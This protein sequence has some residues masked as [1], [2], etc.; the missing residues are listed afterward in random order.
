MTQAHVLP[1]VYSMAFG[2]LLG[3]ERERSHRGGARLALG[4]RTFALLAVV[5]TLAAALGTWVIVVG[6]GAVAAL[7]VVGYRRTN[8]D[9]PGTTTEVAALAT[10]LLG[11]L[12][13]HDPRLA[14][15]LA[16]SL[17]VLLA[18]KARIHSFVREIVTDTELE[19]AL[20]F[21]VI[22][23]VVLPLLPDRAVGP[24]GV[25]NP[26]RI[27]LIVVAFTGISWVGY[28]AV[29]ALGPR[30]G[31]LATGLAS[32]FVSATATTASMGRIGRQPE[33]LVPAVAGAQI[34]SV[35]T[36]IE[37]EAIMIVV[38]P[39]VALRLA[40]PLA[41]GGV[42]LSLA[43]IY[44][45]RRPK[46]AL[47]PEGETPLS[48]DSGSPIGGR[49]FA[50]M[51]ALILAVVLTAALLVGRW[52]AAVFGS[53][54]AV[55]ASG[56][57]GLADAHAGAIS[58]ATLFSKGELHI[59][60]AIAAVAAALAVNTVVKCVVAFAAGGTR[61]GWRFSVGVVPAVLV[62]LAV[63]LISTPLGR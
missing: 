9:D 38:S 52:G 3:I 48:G 44:F 17:V 59:D 27:W 50:L 55:F 53:K 23:F 51:P 58:A 57:A 63:L 13:Y 61:F 19:D 40:L 54:G 33:H 42:V 56:A 4:S 11:A 47:A 28:I 49:A 32:G 12:C 14:T 34:S 10:Y 5:G 31:L 62:V 43:A 20:K 39:H 18:S 45:Y 25:L 22:A 41:C 1:F 36:F 26:W 2:L 15:G 21:L 29:R 24:Y 37:L 8:Q 35:A 7:L 30:R 16:I 46:R 60:A 6:T